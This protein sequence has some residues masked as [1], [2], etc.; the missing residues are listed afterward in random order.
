MRAILGIVGLILIASVML[1]AQ[2]GRTCIVPCT[3]P[4]HPYDVI[5]CQHPCP[6]PYGPVPCHPAGDIVPCMHPVHPYGD[7]IP[8]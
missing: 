3:H 7:V 8:C 6:G 1:V 2:Y 5:P 4:M